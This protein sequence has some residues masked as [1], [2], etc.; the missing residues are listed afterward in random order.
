MTPL[1][2]D[3]PG[4][5]EAVRQADLRRARIRRG[6]GRPL[7]ETVEQA[8]RESVDDYDP[9]LDGGQPSRGDL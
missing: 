1:T 5:E 9:V 8:Q 4:F 3:D 6:L 7:T 2:P